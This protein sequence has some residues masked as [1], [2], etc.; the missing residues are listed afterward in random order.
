[1]VNTNVSFHPQF[2]FWN[3]S[4]IWRIVSYFRLVNLRPQLIDLM[5]DRNMWRF[6][7]ANR[8]HNLAYKIDSQLTFRQWR[9]SN[10]RVQDEVNCM[11]TIRSALPRELD[12]MCSRTK[13]SLIVRRDFDEKC[14][15]NYVTFAL[16]D[17][18]RGIQQ[19]MHSSDGD[20][21]ASIIPIK[22]RSRLTS[23]RCARQRK[24]MRYAV[25]KSFFL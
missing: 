8:M 11:P 18:K 6:S 15:W 17:F 10:R 14:T 7:H 12:R 21:F 23:L 9:R 19:R 20:A 1:M 13:D 4:E 5:I 25:R 16:V 2:T 3:S 22:V 24:Y